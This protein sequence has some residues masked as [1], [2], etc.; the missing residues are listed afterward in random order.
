LTSLVPEDDL[1]LGSGARGVHPDETAGSNLLQ[2]AFV[3]GA[4]LEWFCAL[5]QRERAI[6]DG[7]RC[8]RR[9]CGREE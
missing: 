7:I 3:E 1:L 9:R 8:R 2:I 5:G 4:Q 6:E